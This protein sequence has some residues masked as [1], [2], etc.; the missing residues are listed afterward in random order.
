MIT[1]TVLNDAASLL[2]QSL[3]DETDRAW[4]QMTRVFEAVAAS[5]RFQVA[6]ERYAQRAKLHSQA[7]GRVVPPQVHRIATKELI[8]R[9]V[10]RMDVQQ[11]GVLSCVFGVAIHDFETR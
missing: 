7:V 8:S 1:E 9:P 11:C 3:R 4:R 2:V 10:E 5:F 6:F